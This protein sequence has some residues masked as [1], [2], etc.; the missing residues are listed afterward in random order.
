MRTSTG[1]IAGLVAAALC[2]G[3]AIAQS[4]SPSASPQSPPGSPQSPPGS[5]VQACPPS[6]TDPS[7]LCLGYRPYGGLGRTLDPAEYPYPFQDPYLATMTAAGLNPD[8]VA[9]GATREIVR[10]PVLSGRDGVPLLE[11]R[12]TAS[13]ALYRQPDRAAPLIFILG[14]VGSNPY[15]GLATYYAALFQKHGAHVAV[16]PSPMSWNFALAASRTA[17]P[18]FTPDDS[19]DVYQLMQ[20]TLAVLRAKH[21][22]EATSVHF[23]G[24]SLGALEGAYLSVLDGDEGRIG[25]QQY[26]LVNPPPDLGYALGKLDEWQALG[27]VLGR[28]RAARVGMRARGAIEDYIEDRKTNRHASFDRA[29]EVFASMSKEELQF[30]IAQYIRLVLPE[31]VYVTQAVGDPQAPASKQEARERLR[32]A[33]AF[34][35]RGYE[36]KI[37]V[38]RR[39]RIEPDVT[40]ESLHARGSLGPILERLRANPRVHIMHNAD[41]VLADRAAI[42]ELKA[43]MGEQMT[44]YPYGGHLGNLWFAHNQQDILRYFQGPTVGRPASSAVPGGPARAAA[45]LGT[46]ASR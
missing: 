25:I 23:M 10:V 45:V 12:G 18:G 2:A 24:V 32:A 39:Q 7:G 1:V 22:V 43:A 30:L 13:V 29:A 17:T 11:G 35:L 34:T 41:D 46:P 21:G 8:G 37:A 27:A 33:K 28:E 31:L 19:R 38:P 4:Q 20:Q 40:A 3:T 5:R 14:G 16:L 36:E 15:L 9:R 6:A 42:E 44:V 26:L